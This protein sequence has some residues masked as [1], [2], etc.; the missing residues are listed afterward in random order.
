MVLYL[1]AL[2]RYLNTVGNRCNCEEI[3]GKKELDESFFC[4]HGD[5]EEDDTCSNWFDGEETNLQ[6]HEDGK[7]FC[8]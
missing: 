6:Y 4:L 8:Q 2:E 1:L 5:G 7:F 3:T